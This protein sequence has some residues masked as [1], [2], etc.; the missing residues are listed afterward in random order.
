[1]IRI[2]WWNNGVRHED[3]PENKA[4]ERVHCYTRSGFLCWWKRL[5]DETPPPAWPQAA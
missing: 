3:V 2:C 5:D 1:M 4:M